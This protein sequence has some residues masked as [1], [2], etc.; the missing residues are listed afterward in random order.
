MKPRV[1]IETTIPSYLTAWP[2]TNPLRA[3]HQ[4]ITQ[5][6]WAKREAFEL[7]VS[8]LVI[9]E[10]ELGDAEA[11]AARLA[12]LDG[13]PLLDETPA[14]VELARKLIVGVPLP[15]KANADSLHIAVAAVHGLNYLLTWNCTHIANATMRPLIEKVCRAAGYEPPIICTPEELKHG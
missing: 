6:W 7:Y 9:Q 15:A 8:P 3:A 1:F 5:E 4:Q 2:S 10:C 11:A 14:A 13:I 12:V